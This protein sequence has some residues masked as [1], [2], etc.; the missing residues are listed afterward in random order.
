MTTT[1]I[2]NQIMPPLPPPAFIPG[3]FKYIES[4]HSREMLQ[5][6]Y[7]AITLLEMWNFL[8]EPVDE[9][10]GFQFCSDE[11]VKQIYK[12]IEKLG[13]Y[14]HSGYTF[15]TIMRHMKYIAEH[16][17]EKYYNMTTHTTSECI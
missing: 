16:G 1:E 4:Q 15:G 14:G 5:S 12:K 10:T 8:K 3:E 11:R 13:Y 7:L 2:S 6:A 17:E 9:N